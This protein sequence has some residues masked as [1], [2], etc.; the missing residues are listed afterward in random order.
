MEVFIGLIIAAI[1]FVAGKLHERRK[2]Q[3]LNDAG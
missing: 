2:W 1:G 3:K